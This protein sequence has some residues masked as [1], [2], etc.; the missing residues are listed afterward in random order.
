MKN[1][2]VLLSLDAQTLLGR[3][4]CLQFALQALQLI[5]FHVCTSRLK[6]IKV[7][8]LTRK[9]PSQYLLAPQTHNSFLPK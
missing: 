5:L 7:Q 9:G 1:A 3:N 2:V 8:S 4:S 6:G